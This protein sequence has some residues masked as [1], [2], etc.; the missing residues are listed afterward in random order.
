MV[1]KLIVKSCHYVVLAQLV[2]IHGPQH[3]Q[4]NHKSVTTYRFSS[5]IIKPREQSISYLIRLKPT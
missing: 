1:P 4:L 2:N 3:S 5:L